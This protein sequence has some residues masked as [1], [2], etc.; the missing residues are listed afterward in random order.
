MCVYFRLL[1]C[2]FGGLGRGRKE[3]RGSTFEV[4]G[5]DAPAYCLDGAGEVVGEVDHFEL[6]VLTV[7][8]CLMG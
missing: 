7:F 3:E 4:T 2:G 5:A 1:A 8:Y 6:S